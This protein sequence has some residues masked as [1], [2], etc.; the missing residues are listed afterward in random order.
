[1]KRRD[2]LKAAGAACGTGL[3]SGSGAGKL[4]AQDTKQVAGKQPNMLFL[5]VDE[6]RYPSV[7][8]TGIADAAQFFEAFMPNVYSLW[9][10]GVKFANHHTAANACT[11]A[12]GTLIT[13]LYSQQSWLL[14]T[15][16]GLPY[17]PPQPKQMLQPV[18]NP[19]FPTYGRLL[20]K[21]GYATPY[22]G[23]WHV[24][25]P[26]QKLGGL[27]LYGFS[28]YGPYPDPTGSNLQG[29]YGDDDVP[30]DGATLVYHNDA[31]TVQEAVS[32]LKTVRAGMAPF[33]LTVSLV[34][35]HDREFFPSGTEYQTV[36]EAFASSTSNPDQFQQKLPY[37]GNGPDVPWSE[38][39]LADPPQYGYSALPPNWETAD[40]WKAQGK[41]TT[42][43]F[44][45][46]FQELVWGGVSED[47]AETEFKV[48][49]YPALS[50]RDGV[51][52]APFSYWQRGLDSYTQ[53]ME[54]VDKQ[55][56][57]VLDQLNELPQSVVE[58]TVIIFA[59]DHGEYSGAHGLV[60][61]KLGTVYEEAWHVPLIVVD[62]THRFTE[63]EE[64]LRNGL[65]SSVDFL[66]M[67][68]G[69]GALG[70]QAWMTKDLRDIYANRHD[71]MAMLKNSHAPGRQYVL[72]A[73]DEVAPAYYNF[74][75]A[76]THV[77]GLRTEDFKFGVYADWHP[78][79]GR[80]DQSSAQLEFY[81]YSIEGGRLELTSTPDDPRASQTF[82]ALLHTI[83]PNELQAPLPSDLRIA[84][85]ASEAAHL[86]FRAYIQN[87]PESTWAQAGLRDLLGFG[88]AF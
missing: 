8:P 24:S 12:R 59:S 64:T 32:Y 17:S 31:E 2:F 85:L 48:K 84:Q 14:G 88:G 13:G 68:V 77:L 82:R 6:L 86:L 21:L 22:F 5:L 80:I 58:N 78:G 27:A 67:I 50:T 75:N 51:V 3:L 39:A 62:P 57:I 16:T 38:N 29:T 28:Q 44:I 54:I 71:M 65:T 4:L 34:N 69:M 23:K 7:F 63:H 66:P 87:Q 72:H 73:T 74:N 55:I 60:Q 35:P 79:T 37:P 47:P 20:R 49:A 25:I 40:E 1:M 70:T 26:N 41:P 15:L 53:L 18:L 45:K 81:D 33:C 76:P 43:I 9:K 56:G 52:K 83:I 10:R 36:S 11:P 42:Q 30:Y 61:G 46:E 19:A